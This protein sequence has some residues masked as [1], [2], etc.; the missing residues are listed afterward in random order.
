MQRFS[1]NLLIALLVAGAGAILLTGCSQTPLLDPK[2]PIGSAE[3][4]VILVAIALMLIVVIPVAVMTVLFPWKFRYTNTKAVYTPKWSSSMRLELIVWLVPAAIVTVLA[5]LVWTSTHR[6]DPYKPIE[7]GVRPI[8][9]QVVSLDW[10]WLFIYPEEK[11]AA[12]NQLVF[13]AR[14]PVSFTLTSGT[15]MTSFFIPRLGSQIYAMGG[16]QTRLHLLAD[17]PGVFD[18]QNQQFSGRGYA[19]MNFKAIATTQDEFDQWVQKVRQS[20]EPLDLARY[21]A[22]EKPS[23]RHPVTFF[24]MVAPDLFDRILHKFDHPI[25]MDA[26]AGK[27]ALPEAAEMKSSASREE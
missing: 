15:V 18:G 22:L 24:S 27:D 19:A 23:D 12:V 6:L 14:V 1:H 9:V 5:I 13:P 21:A 11:I 20:Q 4:L 26:G 17:E 16:M 7:V 8:R 2:G 10:K 25:P 3:R